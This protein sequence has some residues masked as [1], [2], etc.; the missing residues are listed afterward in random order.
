MTT[1][2]TRIVLANEYEISEKTFRKWLKEIN[3]EV[4]PRRLLK[5]CEVEKIYE[6]LGKP[7][8]AQAQKPQE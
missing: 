7:K 4:P 6:K 8:P 3:I 5:P 2:K 1:V